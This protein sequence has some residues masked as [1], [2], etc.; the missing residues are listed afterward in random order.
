MYREASLLV[1]NQ[2]H[3]VNKYIDSFRDNNE[4]AYLVTELADKNNLKIYMQERFKDKPF[5]K[6]EAQNVIIQICSALVHL[7]SN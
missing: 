7:H 2:H 3:L 4:T 6:E 1:K 5:S